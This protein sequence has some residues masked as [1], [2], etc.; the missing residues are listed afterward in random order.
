M[1]EAIVIPEDACPFMLP[2]SASLNRNDSA[3]SADFIN[4]LWII[5]FVKLEIADGTQ[6]LS[7]VLTSQI[8]FTL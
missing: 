4:A 8:A 3:V 5:E 1:C 7:F 2:F 6:K